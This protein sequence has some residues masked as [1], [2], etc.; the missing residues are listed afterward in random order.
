MIKR[1]R[2]IIVFLCILFSIGAKA[3]VKSEEVLINRIVIALG[4]HADSLYT[5]LFPKFDDLWKRATE[6]VPQTPAD[7]KRIMN[8]RHDAK[9]LQQFDPQFNTGIL[10]DFESV[11]KK[12]KDSGVHWSDLVLARYELEKAPLPKELTGLEK[13][14]PTRLQGYIYIQDLLTRRT[15]IVA[16]KDIYSYNNNWY[17]GHTVNIL[18][19]ESIDEYFD[20]LAKERKEEKQ[21]LLAQLYP[22]ENA[23]APADSASAIVKKPQPKTDEDE[24]EKKI[25]VTTEIVDRK[26]YVGRFDNEIKVELYVRSLKGN[27]P[28]SACAWEAIYKVGNADNYIKLEVS[29]A[30]GKWSF[31]EEDIGIMELV[32]NGGKLTGTWTSFKDK[33]EY[34]AVFTEKKEVKNRKLFELDDILENGD[35]SEEEY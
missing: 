12:G 14:I 20:K 18:E 1:F 34:E 31:T 24:E 8:I 23:V 11:I 15:Y 17:G 27:C 3:Q 29:R 30:D 10:D 13:I 32:M 4:K 33:T 28:D 9:K 26:L 25:K 7:E 5:T 6:Y 19:A 2:Y 21:K 16:V 35:V 22:D